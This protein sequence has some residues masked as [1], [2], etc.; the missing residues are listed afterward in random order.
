MAVAFKDY[1]QALG[2]SRTAST[3]EITKAFKKLARKCH[4]D[5]NPGDTKAEERFKEIN[6]AHEVLK[7]AEKRRMYDQLGPDWQHGQQFQGQPG[8]ENFQFDFGGQGF[9]GSGFSDFFEVLFGQQARGRAGR[10]SGFGPDPFAGFSA[11]Q[12]RGYDIEADLTITL[13]EAVHGTRR[14]VS[15]ESADGPRTLSVTIQPGVREMARLRLAGQGGQSANGAQGDLYLKIHFAP[16]PQFL[17]QSSDINYELMLAPWQAALGA[18]VRVPTLDGE[19]DLTIPAGTSSGRKLRL[20]GKGLGP[21]EARGDQLIRIG[22]S[23]PTTLTEQQ[24]N[25]WS[26]LAEASEADTQTN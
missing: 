18:T 14:Q 20:R 23:I 9:G 8:F 13:E 25:L 7:D 11:R 5:L 22:I 12:Q 17:V 6:E 26:A 21:K 24:K 15:V 4:P 10:S 1:Y 2:V 19:V 16:H 3:E